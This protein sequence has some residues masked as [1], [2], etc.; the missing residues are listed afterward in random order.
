VQK[1][2]VEL[3]GYSALPLTQLYD[4]DF[5]VSFAL[6]N[7]CSIITRELCKKDLC[8]RCDRCFPDGRIFMREALAE[9]LKKDVHDLT[10]EDIKNGHIFEE[11][12]YKKC[13]KIYIT[14]EIKDD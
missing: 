10:E 5:A 4:N 12:Q 2:K 7:I 9:L 6:P 14:L 3:V 11:E 13:R 8:G 1:K